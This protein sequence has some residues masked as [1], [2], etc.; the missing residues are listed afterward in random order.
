MRTKALYLW[1]LLRTSF[2]FLPLCLILF[3]IGAAFALVYLDSQIRYQ[4]SGILNYFFSGSVDSARN[5][6]SIIA[7]AML[8]VASTVFSITLVALTLASS[9]FGS[10]LLRNFMHDRLNQVVLGTY[11]ATFIYCLL[12]L[13]TL[14]SGDGFSF[15]PNFSVLVAIIVAVANIL[16]LIIFI[17]HISVSIQADNVISDI[18]SKLT[19]TI[20]QLFPEELGDENNEEHEEKL[21]TAKS[22]KS[23]ACSLLSSKSGYLQGI[24]NDSLMQTVQKYD[25]LLILNHRPGNFI[26]EKEAISSVYSEKEVSFD[27]LNKLRSSFLLGKERTPIQDVE[28]AVHQVVEI[29][30]RALSPGVN[31]PYTAIT[32]IDKLTDTMCFLTRIGFPSNYR[33]DSGGMIRVVA[34]SLNFSGMMDVCFNQIRQYGQTTPTILIHLMDSFL[35]MN[36]FVQTDQQ[37]E[38]LE[39][40]AT[41]AL[42]A[43]KNGSLHPNDLHTLQSRFDLLQP[44]NQ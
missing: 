18:S 7:G 38:A 43:G 24:D 34:R 10:R 40:H 4:P 44:K 28:F 3:A 29:A 32:C 39:K 42:D 15:V 36:K 11:V 5:V 6:L 23:V 12:V 1:E 14:R 31:D 37:K 35:K 33:Y 13:Q 9:Q 16:L 20:H 17:H 22:Q 21:Q 8:G 26:V 27:V 19:D 25:L 41:M 30:S 2:W